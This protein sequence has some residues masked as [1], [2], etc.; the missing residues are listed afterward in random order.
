MSSITEEYVRQKCTSELEATH[1]DC[2]VEGDGCDG[3][4]K[5]Q[6][7]VVS[8]KFDSLNLI[9]RHKLVNS[10]FAEE[11]K[12]GTIHALTIKAKTPAQFESS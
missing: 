3:G 5:I 9:K 2:T 4:V 12:S 11:L 8:P 7:L 6:L 1:V 10:V